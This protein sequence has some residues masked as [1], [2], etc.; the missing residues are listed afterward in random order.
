MSIFSNLNRIS[1]VG[2]DDERVKAGQKLNMLLFS[3]LT[4][5]NSQ[6][7]SNVL[8]WLPIFFFLHIYR[9]RLLHSGLV[10]F[11]PAPP[12]RNTSAHLME[13]T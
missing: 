11:T 2:N 1:Y 12:T 9:V 13:P 6:A 10:H 3:V 8:P 4:P 5:F 7:D